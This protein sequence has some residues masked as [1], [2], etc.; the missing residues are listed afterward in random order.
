MQL[1]QHPRLFQYPVFQSAYRKLHPTETALLKV[2]NDILTNMT[3]QLGL[4]GT[5]LSW[6]CSYLSGRTQRISV[7]GAVLHVFY[8][9]YGVPQGS[10]LGPLLFNMYSSKIFDIVGHHLP[11]VHCYADD[12]QLY[13][14]FNPSCAFSQDGAI[15]SMETCISVVKQWM[16][17][18]KLMLNDDKSELIV[19]ASRHLF[20]KAAVNTIRVG[21]WSTYYGHTQYQNS[22]QCCFL[23]L[24][25]HQRRIRKYLSMDA[26]A[27]LIHSFVSS[28][29]DY[30]NRL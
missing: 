2:H 20:K 29:I 23:S 13:L 27:T 30:C 19:T 18:D 7:Q 12:P 14:S 1:S 25:Q 21:D 6:C 8:L 5:A 22:V 28:R 9:R 17:S 3:K 4:N 11:Q 16:T 10:C 26:A 15:R 24:A